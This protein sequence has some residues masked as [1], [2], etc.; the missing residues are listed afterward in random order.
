MIAAPGMFVR[1]THIQHIALRQIRK[2]RFGL[3]PEYRPVHQPQNR[4]HQQL[5]AI[6]E[7]R[8]RL[9]GLR[10][11]LAPT[12]EDVSSAIQFCD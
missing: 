7:E 9:P 8:R 2:F 11:S 3:E 1:P 6:R 5:S 4:R 12:A 10:L